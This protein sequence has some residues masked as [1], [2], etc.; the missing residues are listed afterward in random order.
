MRFV[1]RNCVTLSVGWAIIIFII[2]AT[3]GRYIPSADWLDLI[4]F[5]KFV[6]LSV[7]G[8]LN[9]FILTAC[10]RQRRSFTVMMLLTGL[11][12]CYGASLEWMQAHVF[13]QRSSDWK[14]IIANSTGCLCALFLLPG[15]KRRAEV[16]RTN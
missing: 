9:Y 14:D 12:I 13:S 3:P 4:S 10:V 7:F 16:L 15:I 2:C 6:H 11:A 1:Y 8:V 5:D